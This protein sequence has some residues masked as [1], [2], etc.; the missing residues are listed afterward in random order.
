MVTFEFKIY[1]IDDKKGKI[2]SKVQIKAQ[3]KLSAFA[4]LEEMY[5]D[6]VDYKLLKTL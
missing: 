3:D 4:T 2:S 6:V 1:T 5:P